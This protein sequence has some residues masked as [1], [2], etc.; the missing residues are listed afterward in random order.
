MLLVFQPVSIY[1]Q[2]NDLEYRPV[3]ITLLPGLG[4]NGIDASNYTAKYSL[5]VLGGYHGGLDGYEAGL[6]NINQGYT[7]GVQLGVFN[8]SGGEMTGLNIAG[9]ANFSRRDMTGLQL[10]FFANVSEGSL[11]GL[12][13][14]FFVNSGYGSLRGLQVAGLGNIARQNLQGFQFAGIFNASVDDAQG[15]VFAGFGNFNTGRMQGLAFAGFLNTTRRLQGFQISGLANIAYRVRGMQVGLINY[16]HDFE[17][18]PI[19]LISYYGNGRKSLDLWMSDAGFQN[20]GLKLGTTRVYN[21]VSFGHNP[22][23]TGRQVW[24][25]GWTIGSYK[26]LDEAWEKPGLEGFFR[27]KDFSI[28][29]V[30]EGSLSTRLNSIYSYRY[31]LGRDITGGYGI[32]AGPSFNFLLSREAR[33]NE[34]AWYSIV[35]GERGGSDFAFWIGFSI[36]MQ[37]FGH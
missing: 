12:Q 3:R 4:T 17:G 27:K 32:Y 8:A 1:S 22:F 7:R 9:L 36:G 30:Q 10:A 29:N 31:L 35:R 26:P 18:I 20:I 19:G 14:S 21:M 23:L 16:A 15:F 28:Q 6:I 24:T 34:Y 33:S 5:N 25:L 11:Q 37:F 13:G 2:T